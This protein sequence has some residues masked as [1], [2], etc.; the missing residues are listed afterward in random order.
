M[1]KYFGVDPASIHQEIADEAAAVEAGTT[2][3]EEL[4]SVEVAQ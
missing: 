2:S 4:V 1:L 3:E